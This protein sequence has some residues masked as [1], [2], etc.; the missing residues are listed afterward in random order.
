MKMDRKRTDRDLEL[1]AADPRTRRMAA[2]C[3]H[4]RVSTYEHCLNVAEMS[5]ALDEKLH[6]NCRRQELARGAMLHDYFLYDWHHW[7]GHGHGFSHAHQAAQ[8]A[9]RDFDI[10]ETERQIIES[11]MWPLNISKLPRS[12]EA[13]IVCLADKV[14]S[15]K[16]T[17][18]ER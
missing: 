2:Y 8:N 18:T 13:W 1:L 10:T 6:A 5:L 15:L 14:C 9:A 12:R 3:Q 7:G 4:G 17:L 16:E 11:H